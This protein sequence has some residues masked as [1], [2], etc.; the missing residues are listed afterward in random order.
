MHPTHNKMILCTPTTEERDGIREY[1]VGDIDPEIHVTGMGTWTTAY[2]I[3]Q[4]VN[5]HPDKTILHL[6]IAGA[7]DP[8]LQ[9]GDIV[10][11]SSESIT[12][13][14]AEGNDGSMLSYQEL[15]PSIKANT[16][17]WLDFKLTNPN[18]AL[19]GMTPV[20]S[21]T[22]P[23][24]SGSSDT[25]KRRR[26]SGAQIENMEGAGLFYTCMLEGVTFHS[27]RAISNYVTI[28]DKSKWEFESC[29]RN[30]AQ[31]LQTPER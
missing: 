31:W 4:L 12:D 30:L 26:A 22:V 24:A 1:L 18:P 3:L 11:V 23:F 29:F 19:P 25:I 10:E 28:R 15:V 20:S 21:L 27:I 14:G 2:H 7:F 9:I 16:S 8:E 5:D 13:F 6:G 17:P